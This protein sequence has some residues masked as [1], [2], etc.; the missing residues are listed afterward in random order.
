MG[1]KPLGCVDSRYHRVPISTRI[2]HA[3]GLRAGAIHNRPVQPA[4]RGRRRRSMGRVAILADDLTGALDTAAPFAAKDDAVT[5]AWRTGG[6]RRPRRLRLRH[7]DP[8]GAAPTTPRRAVLACLPRLRDAG[9]G[10]KKLD[11]LM[12]GNTIEELAACA[13]SGDFESVVI[14]PAFPEQGRITRGGRQIVP[15]RGEAR[16]STST[17]PARSPSRHIPVRVLARGEAPVEP[18]V[19]VCDAETAGRP[20][21]SRGCRVRLAAAGPVVRHGGPCPRPRQ[22]GHGAGGRAR[23]PAA[24]RGGHAPPRLRRPG[25]AAPRAHGTRRRRDRARR[26]RRGEGPRRRA[27]SSAPADRARSSSRSLRSIRRPPRPSIVA[28][29]PALAAIEPPEVLV[30]TGGDTLY[31]F[32]RAIG[33]RKPCG[34]RRVEPGRAGVADRRRPWSGVR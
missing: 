30:V 21:A 34:D 32:C 2:F 17:S 4:G 10:F 26:R 25:R 27:K 19:A 20:R 5:V 33:R 18:G 31:R 3:T 11:S 28:T 16:P 22:P 13:G 1:G 7:R 24:L 15:A 29:L 9:I 6:G 14:A 8:R 23:G 12:R